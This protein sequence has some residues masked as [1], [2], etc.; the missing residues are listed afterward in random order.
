DEKFGR[1]FAW[2]VD[3]R[4]GYPH[5]FVPN[6]AH[7]PSVLTFFGLHN[8][9]LRTRLHA[10]GARAILLFGYAYRTNLGLLLRPPAPIVFRGDSHLLG[11]PR[12]GW[13]KRML[14]RRVYRRCAAV[15]S[16][17]LANRAYFEMYG[18]SPQ[19]LFHAPH[20]VDDTLY[21]RTPKNLAGAHALRRDL[22][23]GQR[24]VV[25]FAGKLVASKQPRQLL[26]AF[27]HLA[28]PDAALVFCGDGPEREGLVALA[29]EHPEGVVRFLSFANQSEMPTRY[30][31]A[32]ILALPSS[33]VSETWGLVVNEAMHLE[34]LAWSATV[35]DASRTWSPKAR[36]VGFSRST[37]PRGSPGRCIAHSPRFVAAKP[38]PT[39]LGLRPVSRSTRMRTQPTGSSVPS[40]RF[41]NEDHNRHGLFPARPCARGRRDG[42]DVAPPRRSAG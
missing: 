14:L 2:D 18:V 42:E 40:L 37:M 10:W 13:L 28:P 24:H 7:R 5:E 9:T 3:L 20:C 36:P 22:D 39:A 23:L 1:T 11:R 8:P 6:R 29:K 35:S 26:Q 38:A 41:Q 33:G 12:P 17:G 34:C 32:D 21:V 16:V 25:L 4:S 19:R 31:L 30:A 15:A 27:L